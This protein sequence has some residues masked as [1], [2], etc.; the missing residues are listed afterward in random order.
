MDGEELGA[1]LVVG[2]ADGDMLV[3]GMG[4]TVGWLVGEM[5]GL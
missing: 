5:E 3:E 1:K 4:V 2:T